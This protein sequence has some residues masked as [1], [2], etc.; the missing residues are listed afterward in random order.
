MLLAL[1]VAGLAAAV[2]ILLQ[3]RLPNPF[4]SFVPVNGT[5]QSA[6]GVVP[7][8]GEP[9]NVAGV[10][11]GQITGTSLHDGQAIIHMQIDP[12]QAPRQ[13]PV[14]QR[15]RDAVPE[16]AAQGHGDQHRPGHPAGRVAYERA[17]RSRSARPPSRPTRT[18]SPAALDTDTRTWLTSLI[19]DLNQGLNGRGQDI[20]QLLQNL[21]PTTSQ[22]RQI[23]DLLAAR[24]QEL[25]LIVHNL[26]TLTEA[27]S[28]KDAQLSTVVGAGSRTVQAL[29]SQDQALRASILRLPA[30]L[31][32]TRA[33]ARRP[34]PVLKCSGAHRHRLGSHRAPAADDASPLADAVQGRCFAAAEQ[35]PTVRKRGP[36]AC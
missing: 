8:L 32:T 28:V 4:S 10:K 25:A 9:V 26:G 16:H 11:V 5:F 34:G 7:G 27:V 15:E 20:K 36:A 19:T 31:Q 13:R 35:D 24:R 6:A 2:Y 22:L 23:G 1:W 14:P 18:S 12:T 30:T 21:G 29:A 3:Q 33:D 17:A